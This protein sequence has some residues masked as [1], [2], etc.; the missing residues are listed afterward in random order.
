MGADAIDA[1]PA[2]SGHLEPVVPSQRTVHEDM[3]SVDER[4]HGAILLEQIGEESLGFLLHG[5]AERYESREVALALLIKR[6]DVA[7]V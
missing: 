7:H 4:K 1:L 2:L 5:A 6:S 3:V